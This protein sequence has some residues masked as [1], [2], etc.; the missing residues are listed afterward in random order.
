MEELLPSFIVDRVSFGIFAVNRDMEIVVWNRFMQY[1]SGKKAEEVIGKNLYE[2]F[3]E[4]PRKWLEKKFQGVFLLKNFSF[5]SWEQ[6]PYLFRFSHNRPVTGGID[7]MQ[8]NCTF[9]PL[10]SSSGEV[11]IVCVTIFDATD[12][13]IMQKNLE[14]ALAA[15]KESANRDGLTGI[16]N[17]RHLEERLSQEFARYKRYGGE[18]SLLMFDLDHFKRINDQ[19]GHLAG[20]AVLRTTVSRVSAM[21]RTADIFG[22]YGG[23]EF[24]L[25]LPATDLASAKIVGE[26]VRNCIGGEPIDFNGQNLLVTSSVGVTQMRPHIPSYEALIHEA[27]TALY[28]AKNSGRN[29]VVIFEPDQAINDTTE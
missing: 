11:N 8:Q 27:D 9:M 16:Y 21:V 3:P 18:F 4:L 2:C 24:A 6:R 7:W 26:K 10:T 29:R 14:H 25:V 5:T 13:S 15:L 1:H 28:T 22:R 20:D 17:R 12:N 19:H 23:E